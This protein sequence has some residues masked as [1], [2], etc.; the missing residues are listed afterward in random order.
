MLNKNQ[1]DIIGL[2]ETRFNEIIEDQEIHTDGYQTV[3]N[4]RNIHDGGVAFYVED[5]LIDVKIKLKF[6][7]LELLCLEVTPLNAKSM[8]LLNRYRPPTS[9]KDKHLV[10]NLGKC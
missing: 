5:S 6:D 9:E 10:I 8:F 2:N 7:E 4:D 3:R 1:I